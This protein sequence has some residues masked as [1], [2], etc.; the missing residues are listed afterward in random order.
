MCHHQQQA[1]DLLELH[2][3]R[4][5]RHRNEVKTK[6]NVPDYALESRVVFR[7]ARSDNMASQS[8]K[9]DNSEM[10]LFMYDI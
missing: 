5:H 3:A 9:S 2:E 7:S 8:E 1:E 6:L 10:P 4:L